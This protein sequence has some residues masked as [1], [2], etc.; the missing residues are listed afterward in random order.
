MAVACP[1]DEAV[2][3]FQA[4]ADM[5]IDGFVSPFGMPDPIPY[6]ET[7][8]EQVIPH[9]RAGAGDSLQVASS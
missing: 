3:R 2:Q 6:M 9:V 8:A 5:G 7:F 1:P 4:L